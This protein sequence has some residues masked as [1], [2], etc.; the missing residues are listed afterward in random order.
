MTES[1]LYSDNQHGFR[2][3][4]SCVTQ[5]IEVLD[6]LTEMLDEGMDIDIL[7]LDFRKAFDTVPHA[8]LLSKLRGYGITG[9]VLKWIED[10][11]SNRTQRVRVGKQ[12][13]KS[14]KVTSGIPQGSILGP[15]LF[16]IFVNDLPEYVDSLCKIFADDTKLYNTSSNNPV[17][18]E[19]INKL[20]EWTKK[21]H[22]YFN[23]LKC[24]VMHLG[25]KNPRHSYTMTND[26]GINVTLNSCTEEK[27]L[28]VY[29]DSSLTFNSHV[30]NIISKANQMLG[31][32]KRTFTYLDNDTFLYLYKALV[33]PHLEYA[34]VI[35]GYPNHKGHS[36][37]V[38]KVQRRATRM[39]PGLKDLTYDNRLRLLNLPSLKYRRYR[40]DM[41]QTF[42]ILNNIDKMDVGSLFRM[43]TFVSTRSS[44]LDLYPSHT[45]LN[46]RKY[47]FTNRVISSWNA[48]TYT[49]KSAQNLNNFK[50]LLDS[51][52]KVKVNKYEYD[53]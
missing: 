50:N 5:L 45:R 31:I 2:K 47:S 23:A 7:Y 3:Q 44:H 8:R 53:S 34:N 28:G 14:A 46:V 10:F 52:T 33:R 40:A 32:I 48:L 20:Q 29:F 30:Q 17:I 1:N 22:L 51:D 35:W 43:N 38:E 39:L 41:I 18:Q 12:F 15:V 4:R 24:K 27:D 11:L 36:V 6:D 49:T 21:W 42:K 9:N 25:I 19:D 26:D 16:T 37:A 13:S